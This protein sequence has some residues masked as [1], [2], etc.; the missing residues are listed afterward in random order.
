MLI[1][2]LE[3]RFASRGN[4]MIG[5]RLEYQ[6]NTNT[7]SIVSVFLLK[8]SPVSVRL[9]N[10]VSALCHA[11]NEVRPAKNRLGDGNEQNDG[12]VHSKGCLHILAPQRCFP[13]KAK[14]AGAF[15]LH[16]NWRRYVGVN[17]CHHDRQP[18]L[19]SISMRNQPPPQF[20]LALRA[21]PTFVG[22]LR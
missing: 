9:Q 20:A 16:K 19:S 13:L 6:H 2:Q 5:A 15:L 11:P 14:T 3:P 21:Q 18:M 22:L 1:I 4:V 10:K 8:D 17:H 7:Y 12:M